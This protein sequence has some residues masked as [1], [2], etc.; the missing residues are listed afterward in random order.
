MLR[1]APTGDTTPII[2]PK[3]MIKNILTDLGGVLI[4]LDHDRAVRRFEEIGVHDAGSMLD[5]Y[6]QSGLFLQLESGG[7][8]EEQFVEAL[9]SRYGGQITP[10][11]VEHALLGF[12]ARVDDEK[13]DYIYEVLRPKYRVFCLSNTNPI[14]SHTTLSPDF[15]MSGRLMEEHFEKLYLS[16]RMKVCKPDP[17]IFEMI[18]E[19]SGIRPE[20]TLFLDDGAANTAAARALGFVT[21]RPENGADWRDAI[22][23]IVGEQA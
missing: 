23:R 15:L 10:D 14:V 21:Y 22:D 8:T 6:L 5:P 9:R 3:D 16:Y 12:F 11:A 13:F 18:I 7:V 20:E 19:D 4:T 2:T 1:S 17:R